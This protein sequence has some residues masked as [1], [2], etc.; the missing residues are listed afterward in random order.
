MSN[1]N[2]SQHFRRIFHVDLD[3]FFVSAE[4]ARNPSLMGIPVLVGG[5]API[6]GVVTCASYESRAFGIKAGMPVSVAKRLCP[7]SIIVPTDLKYY[8]NISRKFIEILSEYC[9]FLETLGLDEAYMD[10]TGF[11]SLNG[12]PSSSA[13]VLKRRIAEELGITASVGIASSKPVAKVASAF[14]KPNGLLEIPFGEDSTFLAPLPVGKLPGIG[15]ATERKLRVMGL[16][17]IGE[18]AGTSEL[19]VSATLGKVGLSLRKMANGLDQTLVI[20]ERNTKSIGREFT[21]QEDSNDISYVKKALRN[22]VEHVCYDLRLQSK[23][24][25]TIE[26]KLRWSDFATQ[27]RQNTVK[28]PSDLEDFL[29]ERAVQMLNLEMETEIKRKN[30][31]IR[32]IGFRLSQLEGPILQKR[33]STNWL[34]SG[35]QLEDLGRAIFDIR[36]KFGIGSIRRGEG[37]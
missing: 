20:A 29:Y 14:S 37:P 9:P 35:S 19:K 18:L 2:S 33:L 32:L 21:F 16:Q 24:A 25:K 27:T 3:T 6:R 26:I 4:R 17:T 12:P 36:R 30:R 28:T 13:L 31:P 11:E 5:I 22:L 34:G 1:L 23:L 7:S 10:M 8:K 15:S